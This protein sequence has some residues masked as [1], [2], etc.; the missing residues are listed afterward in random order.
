M[1]LDTPVFRQTLIRTQPYERP[2]GLRA[3]LDRWLR[4]GWYW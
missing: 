4:R 3:V 2:R 1:T